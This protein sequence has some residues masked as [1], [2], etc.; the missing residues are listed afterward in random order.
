[1]TS[2]WENEEVG[3]KF[4]NSKWLLKKRIRQDVLRVLVAGCCEYDNEPS[5]AIKRREFLY[6]MSRSQ[7]HMIQFAF[8]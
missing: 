2:M 3:Q 4:R 1:M 6:W 5:D 8:K 7:T